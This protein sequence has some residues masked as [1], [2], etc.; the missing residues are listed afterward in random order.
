[1]RPRAHGY[2][3]LLQPGFLE[4]NLHRVEKLGKPLCIGLKIS[5]EGGNNVLVLFDILNIALGFRRGL[6]CLRNPV[7][8]F[9]WR[10]LLGEDALHLVDNV[11]VNAE[12]RRNRQTGETRPIHTL[13]IDQQEETGITGVHMCLPDAGRSNGDVNMAA[14]RIPHGAAGA[15]VGNKGPRHVC[16]SKQ[17]RKVQ[18]M[19]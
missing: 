19:G 10:T 18:M 1:M 9:L 4:S 7:I 8:D 13:F 14:K 3:I 17:A 16:R 12:V 11:V 2:E 15:I 5:T 6:H